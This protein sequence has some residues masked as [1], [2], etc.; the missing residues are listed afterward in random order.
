MIG[1]KSLQYIRGGDHRRHH[2]HRRRHHCQI[3]RA[4]DEI[5]QSINQSIND[6]SCYQRSRSKLLANK[7]DRC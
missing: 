5:N 1:L 2:H 6:R 4:A 7:R 3:Q